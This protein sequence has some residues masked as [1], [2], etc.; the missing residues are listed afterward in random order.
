MRSTRN[1]ACDARRLDALEASLAADL[2]TTAAQFSAP[3]L[4]WAGL[5][6]DCALLDAVARAGLLP[7]VAVVFID[8]LHLF[9]ETLTLLQASEQRY[10][11][12]AKRYS[13]AGCATKAEWNKKHASDLYMTDPE[14]YDQA[15]WGL[16]IRSSN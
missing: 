16:R 3:V 5:A 9:P 4:T 15:R 1:A 11:F 2:A 6:G 14:Q 12:A 8:T 7:R 10:G 13:A